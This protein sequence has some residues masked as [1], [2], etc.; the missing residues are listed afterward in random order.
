MTHLEFI[1]ENIDSSKAEILIAHL[2]ELNFSGFE[3]SENTLKA[4][5]Q[6]ENFSENLFNNNIDISGIKYSYSII[7]DQNWNEIWESGFEPVSLFHPENQSLFA[8]IR[9]NFHP[10]NPTALHV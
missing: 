6:A 3:E 7:K 2:N 9:A 8:Y 4:Y 5:I 10:A 1:F